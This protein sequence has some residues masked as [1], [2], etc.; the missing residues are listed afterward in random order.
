MR[1]SKINSILEPVQQD[2]FDYRIVASTNTCYY[3][4][5]EIFLSLKSRIVTWRNFFLGKN[6]FACCPNELKK[7][8]LDKHMMFLSS[9]L[10]I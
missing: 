1:Q 7:K 9:S 8:I 4:E 5:N 3:S 6:L 2:S 10:N